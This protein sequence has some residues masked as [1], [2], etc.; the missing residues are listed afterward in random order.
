MTEMSSERR[1]SDRHAVSLP[2]RID[3]PSFSGRIGVTC[4]VSSTGVLLGTP[5]RFRIGERAQV[6]LRLGDGDDVQV[7]AR[8]GR[9]VR[10]ELNAQDES[11]L[12]SYLMAVRFSEPLDDVT[13]ARALTR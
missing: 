8:E 9:I 2:T 3:T 7:V 4:N 11:G 13:L 6:E 5:S 12:W 1:R 10:L